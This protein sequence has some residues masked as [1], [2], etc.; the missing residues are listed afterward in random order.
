MKET[1]MARVVGEGRQDC[2]E[3]IAENS[4]YIDKTAF[5]REWWKSIKDVTLIA[6]P[7]RFGK[8]LTI[9]MTERFFSNRFENQPEPFRNPEIGKDDEIMRLKGTYPVISM[10]LMS[11]NG[12]SYESLLKGFDSLIRRVFRR[13]RFLV[14]DQ[15][16]P[17]D[18]REFIAYMG[19]RKKDAE[20]R[21]AVFDEEEICESFIRLSEISSREHLRKTS[22]LIKP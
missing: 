3:M 1:V 8:T 6:R 19:T 18:D 17:D 15:E 21:Y 4:F 13:Y 10:T 20:G 14:H 5:I 22:F 12:S 7:G 11:V 2:S 9:N 16:V